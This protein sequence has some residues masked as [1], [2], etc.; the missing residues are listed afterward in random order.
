MSKHL[1]VM[2]NGPRA[3]NNRALSERDRSA[4]LHAVKELKENGHEVGYEETPNEVLITH[5]VD[6]E[7]RTTHLTAVSDFEGLFGQL[8]KAT[9]LHPEAMLP[10]K[11]SDERNYKDDLRGFLDGLLTPKK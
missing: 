10:H 8:V 11:S 4:A 9:V 7:K 6:G 1:D 3:D 2:S 5:V